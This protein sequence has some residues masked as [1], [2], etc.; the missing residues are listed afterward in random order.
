[1]K[2]L[3]CSDFV[4]FE[5]DAGRRLV[6]AVA[7]ER[8]ARLP[9]RRVDGARGERAVARMPLVVAHLTLRAQHARVRCNTFYQN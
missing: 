4:E 1:M 5:K 9:L 2:K 3:V 7:V 8:S 6:V